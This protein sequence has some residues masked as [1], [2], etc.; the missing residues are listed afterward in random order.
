[1]IE[2]RQFRH[3]QANY[4][5]NLEGLEMSMAFLKGPRCAQEVAATRPASLKGWS[6][7]AGPE[8]TQG[9]NCTVPWAAFSPEEGGNL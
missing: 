4:R 2:D 8:P 6:S 1:M 7:P 9:R 5:S 3:K